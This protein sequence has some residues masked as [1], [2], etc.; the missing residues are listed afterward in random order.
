MTTGDVPD[1]WGVPGARPREQMAQYARDDTEQ[2]TTTAPITV[3]V[4]EDHKVLA[5]SLVHALG[6]VEGIEVLD[7]ATDLASG[8]SVVGARR[9]RVVLMDAVL[10]DGDGAA[11]APAVRERSP[12]TV[13]LVISG[14]EYP[15]VINRAIDSGAAGYLSKSQPLADTIGAIRTA[16]AGGTAFTY[17]QLRRARAA[18]AADDGGLSERE[19]EVLQLL[20][21]GC[22]TDEIARA[23]SLSVHTVRNHVRNLTDKLDASSRIEAVAIAHRRGMVS[24]PRS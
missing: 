14:S 24:P 12:D 3:V 23:L 13:V 9:P 1:G 22:S 7:T 11:A 10:P 8:L 5:E 4:V 15:A 18:G 17:D 2:P 19:H 6:G 21:D 16:A 20:A